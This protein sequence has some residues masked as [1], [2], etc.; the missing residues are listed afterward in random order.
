M[1]GCPGP[2]AGKGLEIRYILWLGV[3]GPETSGEVNRDMVGCP[4][5]EADKGV[6]IHFMGVSRAPRLA[7]E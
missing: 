6:E 4:G 2:E 5:P 7:A 1:A 3:Q